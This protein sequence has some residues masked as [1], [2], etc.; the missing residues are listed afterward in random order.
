MVT[1]GQKKKQKHKRLHYA[2][3]GALSE[4]SWEMK[5]KKKKKRHIE[6]KKTNW[7]AIRPVDVILSEHVHSRVLHPPNVDLS[8]HAV[9]K[10]A[11][12][13]LWMDLTAIAAFH[14]KL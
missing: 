8:N 9:R 4:L 1:K 13:A 2:C 10:W 7:G 12:N 6:V 3:Y 14:T 5:K 11:L